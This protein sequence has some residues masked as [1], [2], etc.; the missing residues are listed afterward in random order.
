MNKLAQLL[1]EITAL[2]KEAAQYILPSYMPDDVK[3]M[4]PLIP[5]GT[6]LTIYQ[7]DDVEGSNFYAVVYRG[8]KSKPILARAYHSLQAR[9]AE[10]QRLIKEYS[11]TSGPQVGD[12]LYSS[13]GYEQTNI[14]FYQVTKVGPKAIEIRQIES[15]PVGN[16]DA[17]S[18]EVVPLPNNFTGP[19]LRKT[20]SADRGSYM[21]RITSFSNAYYW[22]GK[23]RLFR[24][25]DSWGH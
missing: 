10:I 5:K 11:M 9:K 1:T 19:A 22:D 15:R 3:D 6:G 24:T 25:G 8:R 20:P 17:P 16:P 7:W 14:D 18:V 13:W 23:K 4:D 21:V 2:K 12:I